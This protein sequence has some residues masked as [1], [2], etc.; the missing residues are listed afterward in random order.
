MSTEPFH[1]DSL[2]SLCGLFRAR[3][4]ATPDQ[5]A[6]RQ[7]DEAR[8]TWVSFTWLQVAAEVER[9]QA[10]LLKEGLAPGDRVA[11]ML[12]N[13]VEWVIFD[14]AAL[15]LGLVTVPLYLDDRPDNA[16]YI[17][18]HAD[19]RLLLVEGKFQHRKL[20]EIV[21]STPRLQRIVSLAEP[22]NG[23]ADWSTRFVVAAEWLQAAA[24]A[25]VPRSNRVPNCWPAS[26]TR[27][28]PQ[29]VPKG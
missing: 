15:G 13:C 28:A 8:G 26:S 23:L 24:K 27:Q 6:Y 7:F 21:A 29:D 19:A 22:A 10:A 4:A 18:D 14:Q 20:A 5:V 25:P 12:K 16:A 11:L 17:L 3:V 1:P 2:G 9:W